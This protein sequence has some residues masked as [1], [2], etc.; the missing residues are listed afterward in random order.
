MGLSCSDCG[1]TNCN[2]GNKTYPGFCLTTHLEETVKAEA[3][4]AYNEP[5]NH[6]V[7]VQ[8]ADVEYEGYGR[9]WRKRLNLPGGWAL[10]K[11]VL[12]PVLG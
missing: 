5:D 3:M 7:M 11:S 12:P 10:R 2:V 4:A 8:A 6:N 9:G 1:V